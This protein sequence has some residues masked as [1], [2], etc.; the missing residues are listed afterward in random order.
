ML[1]KIALLHTVGLSY[2]CCVITLT[3]FKQDWVPT[4]ADNLKIAIGNQC[5]PLSQQIMLTDKTAWKDGQGDHP[6]HCK[7]RE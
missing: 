3:A 1:A 4:V 7:D 6:S 2:I 5:L